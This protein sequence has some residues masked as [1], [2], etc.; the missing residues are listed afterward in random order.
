MVVPPSAVDSCPWLT[1]TCLGIWLL[2]AHP[3]RVRQSVAQQSDWEA[4][5]G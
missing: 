5:I 4:V 1:M 2:L 3:E